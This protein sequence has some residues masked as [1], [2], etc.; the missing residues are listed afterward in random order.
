MRKDSD[1]EDVE[2][3]DAYFM[4]LLDDDERAQ[5]AITYRQDD[6]A[7]WTK[8]FVRSQMWAREDMLSSLASTRALA[9][10]P[11]HAEHA[12]GARP[13]T[14][15]QSA[16][17]GAHR[18]PECGAVND[19]SHHSTRLGGTT[20]QVCGYVDMLT[21]ADFLHRSAHLVSHVL[22]RQ[23]E[24]ETNITDH[25]PPPRHEQQQQPLLVPQ[26][27][28]HE[29]KPLAPFCAAMTTHATPNTPIHSETQYTT[30][31]TLLQHFAVPN[32]Q[33]AAPL[34]KQVPALRAQ[35][36][37]APP[38]SLDHATNKPTHQQY[39]TA[40][41]TPHAQRSTVPPPLAVDPLV[42]LQHTV[43]HSAVHTAAQCNTHQTILQ[44]EAAHTTRPRPSGDKGDIDF[45]T[46]LH[47]SGMHHDST[48]HH[49]PSPPLDHYSHQLFV[50][51][52][53]PPLPLDHDTHQLPLEHHTPP[54]SLSHDENS[55]PLCQDAPA[56]PTVQAAQTAHHMLAN[57]THLQHDARHATR[58]QH[59]VQQHTSRALRGQE[60]LAAIPHEEERY[61][62]DLVRRRG[63]RGVWGGAGG[64]NTV[65]SRK[66]IGF[67]VVFLLGF[68][69]VASNYIFLGGFS[70]GHGS[71]ER[72]G[73]VQ[74]FQALLSLF[75]RATPVQKECAAGSS[76]GVLARWKRRLRTSLS[77]RG[78][79]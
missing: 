11:R 32:T 29:L 14:T 46:R 41:I 17:R 6:V 70:L 77:A 22:K 63:G 37:A 61:L 53:T 34:Q 36:S 12:V 52:D 13:R 38:P 43:Q 49:T 59:V 68:Q 58:L 60:L 78:L 47:K 18:C 25:P 19:S 35:R 76:E 72:D 3:S 16:V 67:I 42:L 20:C 5:C 65:W 7:V 31:S 64:E 10:S 27:C 1:G 8:E 62:W 40:N 74:R 69:L 9:F 39:T 21:A 71:C 4:S 54:P 50:R 66:A 24:Q 55:L 30:H 23:V 45:E 73:R 75:L 44:H 48:A 26:Q 57:D 33:R 2:L 79:K 56:P 15:T 51:H 28:E